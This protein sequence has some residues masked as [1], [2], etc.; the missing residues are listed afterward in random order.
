LLKDLLELIKKQSNC[1]III[2][3]DFNESIT[4]KRIEQFL[5][6]NGLF[7]IHDF[8]NSDYSGRRDSTYERG[9]NQIDLVAGILSVVLCVRG[10]EIINFHQII[11]TDYREFVFD[12]DIESLFENDITEID[13]VDHIKLDLSRILHRRKFVEKIEEKL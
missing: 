11:E 5:I 3:R 12:I 4:S 10:S 1:E 2:A 9:S 8:I 13:C 7:E 6:E